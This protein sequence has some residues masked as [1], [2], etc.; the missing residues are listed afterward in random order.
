MLQ[1]TSDFEQ[2]S[3]QPA[4][5]NPGLAFAATLLGGA[6]RGAL[7]RECARLF[8]SLFVVSA[9]PWSSM[10]LRQLTLQPLKIWAEA[11]GGHICSRIPLPLNISAMLLPLGIFSRGEEQVLEQRALSTLGPTVSISTTSTKRSMFRHLQSLI[12]S[13]ISIY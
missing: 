5:P 3:A 2:A 6:F 12:T 10:Q 4:S 7:R 1:Q 11:S 9:C 8:P 13:K